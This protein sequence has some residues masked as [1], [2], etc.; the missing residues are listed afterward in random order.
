MCGYS[1]HSLRGGYHPI[2]YSIP[3]LLPF[4]VF[5]ENPYTILFADVLR[6]TFWSTYQ[7]LFSKSTPHNKV[8]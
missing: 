6:I 2:V 3:T 8:D 5:V 1:S 4:L 7:D